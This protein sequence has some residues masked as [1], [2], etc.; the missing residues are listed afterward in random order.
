LLVY[1]DIHDKVQFVASNPVTAR[2]LELLKNNILTGRAACLEIAREL[3]HPAPEALVS[4]GLT[5]LEQLRQ[6]GVV[7]GTQA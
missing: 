6:Q 5:I 3:Q 7:L 1:R 4:H 2:L